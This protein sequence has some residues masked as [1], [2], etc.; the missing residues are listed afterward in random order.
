VKLDALKLDIQLNQ[1]FRRGIAIL[2]PLLSDI[3]SHLLPIR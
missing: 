1:R 3:I 2:A